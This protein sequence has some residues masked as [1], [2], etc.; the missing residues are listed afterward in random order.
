MGLVRL[1][2]AVD[3][4]V[5]NAAAASPAGTTPQRAAENAVAHLVAPAALLVTE[6]PTEP[7]TWS[8]LTPKASIRSNPGPAVEVLTKPEPVA[9]I[10][11]P[12][13]ARCPN[14]DA[15]LL[16][17]E[18]RAVAL[19][20]IKDVDPERLGGMAATFAADLPI[21]GALLHTKARLELAKRELR[22]EEARAHQEYL[23]T[24]GERERPLSHTRAGL[25][26]RTGMTARVPTDAAGKAVEALRRATSDLGQM[27]ATSWDRYGGA[28][29]VLAEDDPP[30][31][32]RK[33]DDEAL[34]DVEARGASAGVDASR[35]LDA[36]VSGPGFSTMSP[37]D[38]ASELD[39]PEDVA[40]AAW[41]G[42]QR[43]GGGVVLL[44]PVVGNR[45]SRL[46]PP[47]SN[48][49]LQLAAGTIRP[50]TQG[51]ADPLEA[52][53]TF[54]ALREAGPYDPPAAQVD[55]ARRAVSR[56]TWVEWYKAAE[57]AG[58]LGKVR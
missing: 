47:P 33:V 13:L 4:R 52:A 8:V 45:L 30:G 11:P 55:R 15:G 20:L 51:L 56:R 2:V 28:I 37:D 19:A 26:S 10:E 6:D 44:D 16:Q 5:T 36:L 18:A 39:I 46:R 7:G 1:R 31:M 23:R 57:K 54:S 43:W 50:E 42:T 3:P 34:S 29:A 17:D 58:M 21:V 38:L 24:L 12:V 32:L 40:R 9:N 49:A 53:M 14:L 41:S 48:A 22:P 35:V 25:G 27:A